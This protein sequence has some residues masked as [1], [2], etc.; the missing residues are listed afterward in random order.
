MRVREGLTVRNRESCSERKR[1]G[2][3]GRERMVEGLKERNVLGEGDHV[4]VMEAL[5]EG[6]SPSLVTQG[7]QTQSSSQT[8]TASVQTSPVRG[9]HRNHSIHSRIQAFGPMTTN[10]A[11]NH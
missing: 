5:S 7:T 6:E 10:P 9:H 3:S 11:Q 1:K 2:D 4:R 8:S